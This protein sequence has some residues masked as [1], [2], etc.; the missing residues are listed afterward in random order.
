MLVTLGDQPLRWFAGLYGARSTLR[1]YG[2]TPETYG[3]LHEL[4]IAGQALKL[5]PL[6]HPR[7]AGQLG[8]HS[9]TWRELHASWAAHAAPRLLNST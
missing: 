9:S 4:K 1:S 8:S 2:E 7:Q 5:L 3:R 6:V